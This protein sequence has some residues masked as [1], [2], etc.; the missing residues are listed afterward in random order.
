MKTIKGNLLDLFDAGKFDVIVHGCNLQQDMSG[1][2]AAQI[3]KRYPHAAAVDELYGPFAKLGG[4]TVAFRDD[5]NLMG[6]TII[7]LYTQV[8]PG[9][10]ARLY[11]IAKGFRWL[12]K[13][14]DRLDKKPRIGIP[15][16]G[17]GIGGLEWSDVELILNRINVPNLTVVEF[18]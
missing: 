9:R 15:Q 7:N 3:A 5:D 10:D 16:I 8:Y 12:K 2:I 1:G 4:F 13:W 11:A 18:G 6:G 17:A 14:T